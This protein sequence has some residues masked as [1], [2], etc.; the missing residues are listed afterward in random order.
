D[1]DAG[2]EARVRVLQLRR[3]RGAPARVGVGD[4]DLVPRRRE[5]ERDAAAHDAGTD[6]GDRDRAGL[7]GSLV[8]T[9]HGA[10]PLS[11]GAI[12]RIRPASARTARLSG[13]LQ[14]TRRN[15]GHE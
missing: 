12:V 1:R 9:G 4:A 2:A 7:V 13:K 15:W 10:L 14:R 5:G 3:E 11:P 6:D 8:E